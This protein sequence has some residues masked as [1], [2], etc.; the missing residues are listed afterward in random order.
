MLSQGVS[1]QGVLPLHLLRPPHCSQRRRA[2]LLL[3]LLSW[4]LSASVTSGPPG[5]QCQKVGSY[6]NAR[7][8]TASEL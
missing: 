7:A 8:A 1:V 2:G 3:L 6:L 5:L 4:V